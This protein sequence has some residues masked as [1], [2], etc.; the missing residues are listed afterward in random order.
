MEIIQNLVNLVWASHVFL[1]A[2]LISRISALELASRYP[3][4][5]AVL[6]TQLA[7]SL[8]LN[9]L[10][11]GTNA[12]GYLYFGVEPLLY[13]TYVLV[14]LEIHSQVFDSY[15]GLNI[16]GRRT[17]LAVL[18]VSVCVSV[19]SQRD[20][21]DYSLEPYRIIRSF[22]LL[23]TT[24]CG[25]LLVFLFA[26]AAF[27]VWYPTPLRRNLLVYAFGF[28]FF[29]ALLS[30]SV[31]IRNANPV[32]NAKVANLVRMSGGTICLAGW[33]ALFRRNGELTPGARSRPV[34]AAAQS[35]L[36]AQ[37]EAMNRALESGRKASGIT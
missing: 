29:F 22:L 2:A 32:N 12:Y 4:F 23:E 1:V 9:C 15:Q 13:V 6:S 25:A 16:L 20:Q 5:M 19:F 18:G 7:R 11:P 8:L 26:L 27:L 17:M 34:D 37:L 21:F 28:C 24:L 3:A 10:T 35:R 31:F 14:V 36:L 33:L 30:A